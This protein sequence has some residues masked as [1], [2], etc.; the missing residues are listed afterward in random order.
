MTDEYIEYMNRDMNYDI[1]LMTE[2]ESIA[3]QQECRE[4]HPKLYSLE[5]DENV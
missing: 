4:L 5:N 3:Y 1:V 2:S